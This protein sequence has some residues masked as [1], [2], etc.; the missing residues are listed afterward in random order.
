MYE[1]LMK[2]FRHANGA[3]ALSMNRYERETWSLAEDGFG[4]KH[5]FLFRFT[6]EINAELIG[7]LGDYGQT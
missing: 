4:L 5:T 1:T 7:L 3:T 6:E 2:Q